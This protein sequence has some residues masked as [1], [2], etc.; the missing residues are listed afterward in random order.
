M[1]NINKLAVVSKEKVKIKPT[2]TVYRRV[3]RGM[4]HLHRVNN[5]QSRQFVAEFYS[6]EL[7]KFYKI[8]N[9]FVNLL[10]T[11]LQLHFQRSLC[12]TL[13]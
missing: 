2:A 4:M 9:T 7:I 1:P 12:N 13:T 10:R 8:C 5:K 6:E 11:Q 3:Q